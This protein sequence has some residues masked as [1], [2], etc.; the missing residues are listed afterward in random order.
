M[1]DSFKTWYLIVNDKTTDWAK[2]PLATQNYEVE[3]V[4]D[5]KK[6]LSK[7]MK[8]AFEINKP[9]G[10]LTAKAVKKVDDYKPEN[11][12]TL[13]SQAKELSGLDTL[14]LVFQ[15]LEVDGANDLVDANGEIDYATARKSTK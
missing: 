12:Q 7:A 4:D 3:D 14:T 13:K 11:L 9:Y 2:V 8:D 10:L 1:A 5:L 6:A 15:Y